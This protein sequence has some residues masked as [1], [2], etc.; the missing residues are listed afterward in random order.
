[1]EF[2]LALD[3]LL[4][5]RGPVGALLR[6]LL[7]SL[8]FITTYL[9]LF[10]FV[11]YQLGSFASRSRLLS[12][13][14][15]PLASATRRIFDLLHIMVNVLFNVATVATNASDATVANLT[16]AMNSLNASNIINL[17]ESFAF[18][19]VFTALASESAPTTERTAAEA[20]AEA[21]A[22]ISYVAQQINGTASLPD[23]SVIFF[24][25]LDFESR[26]W[27]CIFR[28]PDIMKLVLGY[29][30]IGAIVMML[31]A[32]IAYIAKKPADPTTNCRRVD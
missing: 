20:A 32:L 30:V 7:F 14:S 9:G 2:Q 21:A 6:N 1:M 19:T 4:G 28:L 18:P 24:R 13:L 15:R 3:E 16:T 26:V 31:Q 11:P 23:A 8:A 29:F 22:N 12:F 27:N 10:G 17:T 5:F 25:M